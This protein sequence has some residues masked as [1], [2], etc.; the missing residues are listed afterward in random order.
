MAYAKEVCG[1]RPFLN[2]QQ[3]ALAVA[4]GYQIGEEPLPDL[5]PP[6]E[7]TFVTWVGQP[8][9]KRRPVACSLGPIVPTAACPRPDFSDPATALAGVIKRAASKHPEI[10]KVLLEELRVFVRKFLEKNFTPLSS[11]CDV[12]VERWL[13]HANYPDW[14]KR[15]LLDKYYA[16]VDRFGEKHV[17]AKC[18]I[19]DECYPDFKH[20]RGI[21]SRTDEYKTLV[22][23]YF[24][25]IEEEVYKHPAFVK[26]IPVADRPAYIRSMLE[27][28]GIA[29]ATD[30][31]AYE[32]QFRAAIMEAVEMQLY[33]YMTA[34][35]PGVNEFLRHLSAMT[36]DQ[37]CSFRGFT[38]NVPTCRLSGEMCT[39]LGNGFSNLMFA[40]FTAERKGCTDVRI[41]VEGD[42][43]LMKYE[44][45][46]LSAEDFTPLG[47]TIKL[48]RHDRIETASF[49][50]IIFDTEEL[51]NLRNPRDVLADFGWGNAQ[52]TRCKFS[53]KMRLLRCKALSLAH[54]YPGC[55]II[56]E[57]AHYGLRVTRSFTVGKIAQLERNQWWRTM[58][59]AAVKDEWKIRKVEPGPRSRAIVAETFG[60]SLEQQISIEQYLAGKQDVG[61]LIHPDILAIMPESWNEYS[62][63][64]VKYVRPGDENS[65]ALGYTGIDF[66]SK[67][68]NF[69]NEPESTPKPF[70]CYDAG[71]TGRGAKIG[72]GNPSLDRPISLG[73]QPR[74]RAG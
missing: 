47:L 53:K 60:I 2:P 63:S 25:L 28:D 26:H 74:R 61:P 55:P 64:Y 16:I 68:V 54:Q 20:A 27:G 50:G 24:K 3:G 38:V 48:E 34:N 66:L 42:D 73:C 33:E 23:P 49:C 59:E 17:R 10:D 12:S 46:R 30:Y 31:T 32:S 67:L 15:E 56:S 44:G 39:S 37:C 52:Y 40:L 1:G 7:G 9:M 45:P 11:D 18:F 62:L 5:N 29:D 72:T 19:K 70:V 35:L 21:Y 8:E 13:A 14:R 71:R 58:L 51:L 6:K 4:Y 22:G 65:Q 57:L 69:V 43:G 36:G 41:V